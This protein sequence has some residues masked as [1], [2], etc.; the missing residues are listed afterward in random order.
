[1]LLLYSHTISTTLCILTYLHTTDNWL[2]GTSSPLKLSCPLLVPVTSAFY[3]EVAAAQVVRQVGGLLFSPS[4]LNIFDQDQKL[5]IAFTSALDVIDS[6]EFLMHHHELCF[7]VC[8]R[9]F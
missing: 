9:D 4:C 7:F 3:V 1:M 5:Q 6:Y 2:V 8:V